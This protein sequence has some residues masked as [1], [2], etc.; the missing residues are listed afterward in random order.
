MLALLERT[1]ALNEQLLKL[2]TPPDSSHTTAHDFRS[3]EEDYLLENLKEA[4]KFEDPE[5]VAILEDP[6]KTEAYLAQFR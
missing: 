1:V 3:F 6:I 2:F 4:A 5:A